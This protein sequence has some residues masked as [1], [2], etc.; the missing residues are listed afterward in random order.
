MGK[1]TDQIRDAA[2]ERRELLVRRSR[3]LDA[4]EA[5]AAR[6]RRAAKA[7]LTAAREDVLDIIR[8][9]SPRVSAAYRTEKRLATAADKAWKL[10]RRHPHNQRYQ[11]DADAAHTAE[12]H[13]IADRKRL[14]RHRDGELAA[15]QRK[16][17]IAEERLRKLGG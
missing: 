3:I 16:V 9:H 11:A 5:E 7:A 1:R 17:K 15:A 4:K 12:D 13:A 10:A 8:K 14:I 6:E 2:R